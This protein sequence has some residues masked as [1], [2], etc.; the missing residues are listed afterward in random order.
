MLMKKGYPNLI[1]QL[2]NKVFSSL[3]EATAAINVEQS[4]AIH[5]LYV[6]SPPNSKLSN[7]DITL[8]STS[9]P[10]FSH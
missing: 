1:S 10:S 8:L 6:T 9:D 5:S 2:I 3:Q 4:V 7:A